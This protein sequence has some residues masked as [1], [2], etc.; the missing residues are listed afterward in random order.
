M[1][2]V[3]LLILVSL[4]LLLT[5]A[6]C[7]LL[8][9]LLGKA[10]A[11]CEHEWTEATC[12]APK[13]CT[14]CNATEGEAAAHNWAAATCTAP[15]TCKTC[16]KT[17]GT[18]N[19][20]TEVTLEAVAP[21]CTSTGLTEGKKCSVCNTVTKEQTT[22]AKLA[23]TE[24][25][26]PGTAATCTTAGL[27]DGKQCSV[28]QTWTVP[29]QTIPAGNHALSTIPGNAPT[30]TQDGLTE[31]KEC[32][33]C[34]EIIVPQQP[35]PA[36]GHDYEA[37]VTEPTCTKAGSTTY[38][39]SVCGDT[40]TE[41]GEAAL[42]HDTEGAEPV[43]EN[44]KPA[45]C[46]APGSYDM[47]T[48]CW[49]CGEIAHTEHF[50]VDQ[51]DHKFENYTHDEGS[52][53]CGVDGTKTAY[54][55]FECGTKSTVT[56]EG[57][58][59]THQMPADTLCGE[60]WTCERGCGHKETLEHD[61]APATCQTLATCKKCQAT[62]GDFAAHTDGEPTTVTT[63]PPTCTDE[64]I[65]FNV[66]KC[67][68]CGVET[69]REPADNIP[70]LGHNMLPATCDDPSTCAN[71]CGK[72]EGEAIAT[73]TPV[74][75]FDGTALTYTCTTCNDTF[76]TDQVIS[77]TG[78]DKADLFFTKNGDPSVSIVDGAYSI[79]AGEQKSQYMIYGPS[80]DKN[81]ANT[82]TGWNATNESF[83]VFSFRVQPGTI[84]E[85]MRVIVM[86]SRNN[87]NWD[88][89]GKELGNPDGWGANS[90]DILG[91][92]PNGDGT[93]RITGYDITSNVLASVNGTDWVDIKM[94]I[95]INKD[96]VFTISYYINDAFVNT[97]TY[98]LLNP[99]AKKSI[100]N[101]DINNFYMCGWTAPG[102]GFAIDDMFFGYQK[103]SEW[104]FDEH[105]HRWVDADCENA[106]HCS[107]CGL[108]EG[109]ALG[110]TEATRDV[111]VVAPDCVN[112]GSHDV[113][114]YCTV[115]QKV[116]GTEHVVDTATG[117]TL[118]ENNVCTVCGT[119]LHD[120][121]LVAAEVIAPTCTVGG[122]TVYRCNHANCNKF[123]NRDFTD[124]TGHTE[125]TIAA[126][127]PT[128]TATGLT[129][130]KK[131]SVCQEV[132]EAQQTVPANGHSY[133]APSC[134][135]AETCSVCG[136]TK[137]QPNANAH[138]LTSTYT[139]S[140][141]TYNCSVCGYSFKV[142]TFDYS[143]GTNYNGMHANASQNNTVYTTNG[144]NYPVMKDG[145]L[146]FIRTDAEA[147]AQKQ[148]QMWL[149]SANGGTNKF[150]G[151]TAASNSIGYLAFKID[152]KTDVN[153]EMKLVDHRVDSL[154]GTSIR[155]GDQWAINDPVFRVMPTVDGKTELIGFN[156]ISL[157]KFT[158]DADG[159]I[160]WV[161][162]AIQ[163]V[164][165]PNTDK[166]I[167]HYYINGAYV[168]TSSRDLT[169]H[170]DAIQ[171]VY[172]N[173]NSKAAGCGYR[174]DN[175]TFGYS[176]HKH[177]LVPTVVNGVLA[178][179]CDC[180]TDFIIDS[181]VREWNGDGS[182]SA[183]KNVPNGNVELTTNAQG[184]YEYIFKPY[185][186]TAPDFSADGTQ[187]GDGWFEYDKSTYAGGQLQM[188]MPSNNRDT[189]TLTG[190][191]CEND[192]VGVIS[193]NVK[194]NLSRHPDWD[195]SL[196][197]S[198]GKPRN[199]SDW[200]D[201]GS[202][203]D[204]SINIFTIEEYQASGI[205]VK[206][207]LNGT[208]LNLTT[209]PVTEDGWSEW[210]N[211]MIVIEMTK[212]EYINV[213]YYI[214]GALLGT[215]T[216]DLNNPGGART[217]N[218]KKIEAL[219]ISGWTYVP[220]TGIVFDDFYFGYS[221]NGHN[222]LDG[223]VHNITETTCGEKSTCSC[224]WTGYTVAHTFATACAPACSV[225]GLANNNAA[226]HTNLVSSVANGNVTYH[227]A[228]CNYCYNVK[229]ENLLTLMNVADA[230]TA[231]LYEKTYTG[232]SLKMISNGTDTNAQHQFWFPGQ[233]EAPQLA[234]FTN[235]NG[236]TGFLSFKIN[237]KD[238]HNTGIE[239]K[240]N[241]NRGTNDW[242]GPSNNGWSES[243]VGIF[244]LAPWA[245]DATSIKLTGYNGTELGYIDVTGEDGWS[246]W[247]DV[248][249]VMHLN[250]DG[251]ITVEYY[252]NGSL[253]KTLHADFVIWTGEINSLYIN[254]RTNA[255]GQ[256]YELTD[257]YFG[258]AADGATKYVAPLY[259]E[260]I[261]ASE[262][263]D[264]ALTT[265]VPG[266][267]KQFDQCTEVNKQG[268]TPVYVIA[269]GKDGSDVEALYLSR[270]YAWAG[271]ESEQFSE[272]RLAVN[273]E[274][275]SGPATVS[276][277]FDYKINGTVETND[278]YIFKDLEGNS[279]SADAYVQVKTAAKH[280]LAGDDY[281]ELS[282]TDLILDGEWHTITYTFDEP[283]VIIDILLNL[284]HF[285][286]EMLIANLV[287][288]PVA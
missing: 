202:W 45:T 105:E 54:C 160:G 238:H 277:S 20:H 3:S 194:T 189:N 142:D 163:I 98:D 50:T 166:V 226:A 107:A 132:L 40:Y 196:T 206:G 96:G 111:N 149:P 152:A 110:H 78:A 108:T 121:N 157:G 224:G 248:V 118:D 221:A 262:V 179:T 2:K 199:A 6:S 61:Y 154:N 232:T 211:V 112:D 103:N 102:T 36:T 11:E 269:E 271:N 135:V 268:G 236:A 278:R 229:S 140:T 155:W 4:I 198:V 46:M 208:N 127:A 222:T 287:V 283:L 197:F 178:Y 95:Q 260:E 234:G 68:V 101:L 83:G 210:F 5:F 97:Y 22:V 28:C 52:E 94:F 65:A 38:T 24:V 115:C 281:P 172:L 192:A 251:T 235:A 37:D 10:P 158:V 27:T 270:T 90:L 35:I 177:D 72:T 134:A 266:K 116:F 156:S 164:L 76:T 89:N 257:L 82:M 13:T 227:C 12:T 185:T 80:N 258:Y 87:P 141:L 274:N 241:A 225:C 49:E 288:T 247:I 209:I 223:H 190:F 15:K 133:T 120:C 237:A 243:S 261:D 129:A 56:D 138:Q 256:G 122:Y 31:G 240:V 14:K 17:E 113:E 93:F 18:P 279:F 213:Y 220:N 131:C 62:T 119:D 41:A 59:L 143:D 30:C 218:P 8:D 81:H 66:T 73:H 137:G 128:C 33:E 244:R 26:V 233:S 43:K 109:A 7:T 174:I 58:A 99:E 201:G 32:L 34:H 69:K 184:Q 246:G 204:D 275:K 71:G 280:E 250:T 60:E 267:I 86:S 187:S 114:T 150:S 123:E 219:Q 228:D 23:H 200:N 44:D 214:N 169:T 9:E 216:R 242:G 84:T 188:W 74:P 104:L 193:F 55:A 151:F 203:T 79:Q 51:L 1:K 252:I 282:G 42:G 263:T 145:Y 171:G 39:C 165:D 47:V 29:Q 175:L 173:F 77:Y 170:T 147:N 273:G 207:G 264:E 75:N 230:T 215:D 57:T 153:F 161:D 259:K 181:E 130:G 100:L 180:G 253:F 168:A 217:L 124:P 212:E 63:T 284:Y 126:V 85:T 25:D 276:F 231:G 92:I 272:F 239:F 176:A 139:G 88:A 146:E 183:I 191:S 249:V 148:L 254:G 117:H 186:D 106:K 16:N 64:G 21:T 195:T 144:S 53:K 255:A 70:A 285:Q 159:F 286:G 48:R 19:G 265:I 162:V 182:D 167:A 245:A 136:A 67:T 205:V 91:I 125:E